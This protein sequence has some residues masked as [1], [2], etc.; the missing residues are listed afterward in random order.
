MDAR[1]K[2]EPWH[3]L[4]SARKAMKTDLFRTRVACH[5]RSRLDSQVGSTLI[6][7]IVLIA[8]IVTL[9]VYG[10]RSTQ[11]ELR[12]SHNEMLSKQALNAAEAGINHVR[13]VLQEDSG[14]F[15]NYLSNGGTGGALSTIGP[16]V[17]LSDG[18]SYRFRAFGGSGSQDG[19]YVRVVDD[20]DETS[21]ADDPTHDLNGR[22]DIIS[23]GRVGGAERIVRARAQAPQPCVMGWPTPGFNGCATGPSRGPTPFAE[24]GT[25]KAIRPIGFALSG[26]QSLDLF[27]GDENALTLGASQLGATTCTVEPT[28][29]APTCRNNPQVGCLAATDDAQRP[30][31]PSLFLTD[32][33]ND[34]LARTGDWQCG[35]AAQKPNTVCGLWKPYIAGQNINNPKA[36]NGTNLGTGA[37]PFPAQP[38]S[39]CSCVDSTHCTCDAEQYG[40]EVSWNFDSLTDQ[41][42]NPLI[43]GHVYR[44]QVM[45][46]DGDQN[47]DGGDV[48]ENCVN[49]VAP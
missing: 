21:G 43:T 1:V 41:F 12:I 26:T 13:S 40:A 28:P 37:D 18:L 2:N 45:V 3:N 8:A 49:F 38:D 30:I 20:H 47:Q 48:G 27:Y 7:V 15:N 10:A 22:V 17:T 4:C 24:N 46:H 35:G 44:A 32:I 14:Q 39:T 31:F 29:A 34:P 23:R 19:Y 42:G 9:T 11:V 36:S 33:T 5:A 25:L 16:V 6:V